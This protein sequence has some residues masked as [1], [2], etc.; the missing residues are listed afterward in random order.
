MKDLLSIDLDHLFAHAIGASGLGEGDLDPA[1]ARRAFEAFEGRRAAGEAGFADLGTRTDLADA[2]V[3]AAA[4]IREEAS[5]FV[6]LGICERSW[7]PPGPGF[8]S[9]ASPG[10]PSKQ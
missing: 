8:M 1:A 7:I 4:E 10:G 5:D 2:C 9:S 6:H 3:E